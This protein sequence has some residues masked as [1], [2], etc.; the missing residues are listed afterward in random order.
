MAA[1][2]Y[3]DAMQ[4][5]V[6]ELDA[7]ISELT[8]ERKRLEQAIALVRDAPGGNGGTA[9]RR[10]RAGAARGGP[11]SGASR[12]PRRAARAGG[13]GRGSRTP[14]VSDTIRRIIGEQP[15]LT[16]AQV[17]EQGGLKRASTATAISKLVRAG[18]A[19][20]D[21]KGG[22]TLTPERGAGGQSAPAGGDGAAS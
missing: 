5:R 3:L 22:L 20:R 21:A 15:G 7:L 10:R 14:G 17:A 18:V 19:R 4:S 11:A 16:A 9:R 13:R 12:R 2:A 1:P 8:S 6:A